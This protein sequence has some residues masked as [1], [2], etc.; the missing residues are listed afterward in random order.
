[1]NE[2]LGASL[3]VFLGI[4]V[5]LFGGAAFLMG[6]ALA[7]TWRPIW[8]NALHGAFLAIGDRFIIYALFG[9]ELLSVWG[10]LLHAAVLI[11]IALTA[12]RMTRA[13]R[14]V[15][16]YPWLYERTGLFTWREKTS[17]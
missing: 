6:Q 2:L 9:G 11:A 7:E 12:Y 10:Y 3:P 15:R 16:Q 1:M 4:T 8:Q 13:W 17:P 14:I 5:I